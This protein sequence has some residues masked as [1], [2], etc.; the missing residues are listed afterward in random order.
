MSCFCWNRKVM[1]PCPQKKKTKEHCSINVSEILSSEI[2]RN[3]WFDQCPMKLSIMAFSARTTT[4][5]WGQ[6]SWP[7][8]GRKVSKSPWKKGLLVGRLVDNEGQNPHHDNPL[9]YQP[10]PRS[11]S[12]PCLQWFPHKVLKPRELRELPF[13]RTLYHFHCWGKDIWFFI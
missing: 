3:L 7:Y 1:Y 6:L 13:V 11:K 8:A 5:P 2:S 12:H 9:R 10:F 4:L